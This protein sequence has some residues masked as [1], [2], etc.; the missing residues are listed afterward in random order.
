MASLAWPPPPFPLH[1]FSPHFPCQPLHMPFPPHS[2]TQALKDQGLSVVSWQDLV[3]GGK[4]KPQEPG[5]RPE[6]EDL[7]TIMYTSGTT[8][9]LKGMG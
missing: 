3:E 4:A 2:S 9:V 5:T 7:C 8:G 1:P 6:P